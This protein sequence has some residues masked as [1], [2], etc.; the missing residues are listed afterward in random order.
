MTWEVLSWQK[1]LHYNIFPSPNVRTLCNPESH[2][3]CLK[4]HASRMQC[5]FQES[6]DS[7][8][9]WGVLLTCSECLKVGDRF[10]E[11]DV[12][13]STT[14]RVGSA[15]EVASYSFLRDA[16]RSHFAFEISA[17]SDRSV[18]LRYCCI[19]SWCVWLQRLSC[20]CQR[21]AFGHTSHESISLGFYPT[22]VSTSAVTFCI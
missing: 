2:E 5:H 18:L 11:V 10:V 14:I 19:S 9:H 16:L 1:C 6:Y 13:F 15:V 3:K 20:W 12:E 7:P 21:A 22:P 4:S 8:S 17:I